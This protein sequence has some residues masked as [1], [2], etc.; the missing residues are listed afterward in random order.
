MGKSMRRNLKHSD[1]LRF[2]IEDTLKNEKEDYEKIIKTVR[3]L[4]EKMTG[5]E[6]RISQ[7]NSKNPVEDMDD[8]RHLMESLDILTDA[9][10]DRSGEA[11]M[12]FGK[13][14]HDCGKQAAEFPELE[15]LR[16]Q[17]TRREQL[18]ADLLCYSLG[19][20]KNKSS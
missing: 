18:A 1:T 19:F 20:I 6:Q 9:Q 4:K 8:L 14:K 7:R 13:L 3:E 12:N 5:I 17:C 15:E 16:M 10:I 11:W 2:C